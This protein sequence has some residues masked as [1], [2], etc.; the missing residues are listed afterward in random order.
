MRDC[1]HMAARP[2]NL[3]HL[4]D[5]HLCQVD[6]VSVR[7]VMNKRAIGYLAWRVYRGRENR[8]AVLSAMVQALKKQAWDQVVVTGDLTHLGLPSEFRLARQFL[9]AIGRPDQVFVIPGNHDALVPSAAENTAALLP[10][11]VASDDTLARRSSSPPPVYPSVRIR[12]DVALIGLSTAHPTWPFSAAGI[13]GEVQERCLAELLSNIG[14]QGLFRVVLIH[15]PLI[16]GLVSW[17]KC[18]RD[19]SRVT[20]IL[21]RYGAELV[22]HGHTHRDFRGS[23]PGPSGPIPEFGLPS[24]SSGHQSLERRA[25][26]RRFSIR[27]VPGGWTVAVQDHVFSPD[28]NGVE[29]SGDSRFHAGPNI[30]VS[31]A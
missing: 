14:N 26:F 10:D 11:Y 24:T 2:F 29:L 3:V 27:R 25:R 19:A 4:S 6:G 12:G 17:R 28:G 18:L 5:F 7:E 23:L 16:P 1:F 30:P 22:L 13:I 9:E 20:G 15:H 31:A 8:S 21:Q